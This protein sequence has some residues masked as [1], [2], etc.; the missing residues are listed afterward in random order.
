M[1]PVTIPTYEVPPPDPNPMFLEKRVYQG[2]Q[3]PG[4]PEPVHRPRL[5]RAR[6]PRLAGRPPR[7][8]VPAADGPARDRRPHPRR[9]TTGPTA[10]TS[11]T[12]RTSSSR[13]SSGLARAVDLAAASSSTGRST[14]ARRRT[15]PSDWS[16]EERADGSVTVWCSEHEPM[17]RMKGMHGITAPPRLGARRGAGA[18]VN[19][20]P[21][22]QTFLWWANVAARVHDEYQ[23]FFPP[24]VTYVADHA[25]RA[26]S[27]F[28]VARGTLLR[29]RLR[30][31]AGGGCGPHAGTGTSRCR[32]RTWPWAPR[33]TSSAATTTPPRRASSTGPTTTSRPA[34]SSGRGATTP[35][36]TRGT[37]SS[38]TRTGRTSS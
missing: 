11:S 6:R 7:E 25:R 13:R 38:P 24:D 5:R 3:R 23:S 26:M 35:S 20:T 2:S 17:D 18:A 8:P 30:V 31:A 34:R 19:R 28:P 27:R 22:T 21:L 14:I 16:I 4:L 37:G 32:R 10:T 12:A 33:R 29:R 9:A 36:A 15:C 1:E